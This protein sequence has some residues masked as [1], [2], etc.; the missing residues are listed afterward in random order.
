M[1]GL[2]PAISLVAADTQ[3]APDANCSIVVA[4][5]DPAISRPRLTKGRLASPAEPN[6]REAPTPKR[7]SSI[8]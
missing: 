3:P 1:A 4:G 8:G 6:Y 7:P 5:L 2:D